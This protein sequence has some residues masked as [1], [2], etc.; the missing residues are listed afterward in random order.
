MNIQ[1]KQRLVGAVVLVALAVIFIPMLLP[2]EGDLASGID[3]SNI[4]PEPDYRFSPTAPAPSAPPMVAAPSV[5]MDA[6]SLD[7]AMDETLYTK[8]APAKPSKSTPLVEKAKSVKESASAKKSIAIKKPLTAP[9][10]PAKQKS[11]KASGWVVQVGSFSNSRNAHALRD[12]LRKQGHV[13]FVEAVKGKSG[14]AYRVR[15]GPEVSHQSADRL[16]QKLADT[17]GLKGLVQAYP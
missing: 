15:I 6:K 1:L 4:P 14:T 2:G 11:L 3:G 5:P 10:K 16:R 17:S 13:T 7:A 8:S 12:K 9:A